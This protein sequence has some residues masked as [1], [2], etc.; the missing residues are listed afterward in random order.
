MKKAQSLVAVLVAVGILSLLAN[1]NKDEQTVD[2]QHDEHTYAAIDD[3]DDKGIT[4]ALAVEQT[5][6]GVQADLEIPT[7]A[8]SVASQMLRREAYTVSYN[9]DTKTPNWV[10]WCLTEARM[11]GD[12]KRSDYDFHEDCDVAAPRATDDDY[13]NKGYDRGHLCPAADNKYSKKAMEQSFLFTNIC[14]QNSNLN[15]GDWND[16]E[17]ECRA[18]AK[19]YGALYI[20]AGPIY[21]S[22]RPKTIGKNKVAV[23]D[24]FFKVVLRLGDDPAAIGFV[25]ENKASNNSLSQYATTVD[26]V[27]E[28]TDIDF[29]PSLDDDIETAVEATADYNS[30]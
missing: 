7:G 6:N 3:E 28:L 16:L 5:S 13:Y 17:Q 19:A 15:R 26:A 4:S 25:C 12:A 9:A 24:A 21:T 23:P 2:A 18:W 14:P 1:R 20:V 10:A 11:K 27:E 29:F 22:S 8:P 30:W